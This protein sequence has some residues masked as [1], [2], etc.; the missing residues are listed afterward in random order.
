VQN[1][2]IN[3]PAINHANPSTLIIVQANSRTR[4]PAARTYLLEALQVTA[5]TGLLAYLG[6]ALF[7]YAT[8][9]IKESEVEPTGSTQTQAKALGLLLLVQ[10]HPATWHV[11]K[12]RARQRSAMLEAQLLAP[13]VAAAR[14]RAADQSLEE[15][16][17]AGYS[18]RIWRRDIVEFISDMI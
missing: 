14:S 6:I 17:A 7:H 13:V 18:A 1:F 16:A 11:Y 2:Q 9:L 15:I 4:C 12:E 3:S 5:K 10:R 8:L